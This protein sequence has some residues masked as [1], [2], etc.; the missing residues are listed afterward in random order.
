MLLFHPPHTSTTSSSLLTSHDPDHHTPLPHVTFRRNLRSLSPAR[1]SAMF[2]FASSPLML[3]A[4]CATGT[5]FLFHSD[6]VFRPFQQPLIF[7][8]VPPLL[9]LIFQHV[10]PLLPLIFQHVPPF[11][12]LS[13]STYHP[14]CPLSSSTYHPF[15]PLSSSTYHPF[16]PL[17]SST[18]HPFCPLS[19]STYHPSAPYLP[20]HVPPL[21]PL[22]SSTYHPFCPLSSSTYHPFCPLSSSTY[23]PS[24]LSY[25]S[26]SVNIVPSSGLQNGY[27]AN[28]KSY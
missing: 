3:D 10:P 9:P 27:R 20:A 18:Y 28:H 2:I 24:A 4:N 6:V 14:F 21:L 19:S 11:C 16:C 12:P 1:L 23:P 15:C 5:Y 26:F 13:S 25:L 17:S 7:Q 8:H 22:S